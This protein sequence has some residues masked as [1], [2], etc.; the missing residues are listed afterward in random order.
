MRAISKSLSWCLIAV[1]GT[2]QILGPAAQAENWFR[3][4]TTSVEQLA[5]SIDRLEKHLDQYGTVVAKDPDVWGQARLTKYRRD[6]EKILF[7]KLTKFTPTINASITRSDQAFV[8]NA[9]ALQ[10][11]ISGPRA[12]I[13]GPPITRTSTSTTPVQQTVSIPPSNQSFGDLQLTLPAVTLQAPA[14]DA[15]GNPVFSSTTSSSTTQDQQALSPPPASTTASGLLMDFKFSDT[16][17][18]LAAEQLKFDQEKIALEPTIML[19]QLS[20]YL[21]HLNELRRISDG[22]DKADA[23]GYALHLVRLPISVMPGKKTQEGY[24]AE[25]NVIAK[26]HLHEK[27]LPE[28]FR[29]LVINDLVDQWSFPVA[30]FLD[31]PRS[32]AILTQAKDIRDGI[33]TERAKKIVT[34]AK[35]LIEA[36]EYV[37][38]NVNNWR[39]AE[40]ARSIFDRIATGLSSAHEALKLLADTNS[41]GAVLSTRIGALASNLAMAGRV[42]AKGH[43]EQNAAFRQYSELNQRYDLN[44]YNFDEA[45][46][47][48]LEAF[49]PRQSR[50][51][52]QV[53]GAYEVLSKSF[54][55]WAPPI[56][57]TPAPPPQKVSDLL[58]GIAE[59]VKDV[60]NSASSYAGCDAEC[61][62]ATGAL[63]ALELSEVELDFSKLFGDD[64]LVSPDVSLSPS[65][66]SSMPFPASQL[67]EIYGDLQFCDV[68]LVIK[69]LNKTRGASVLLLDAQKVLSEEIHAA[70]E[71]LNAH[72][73]LWVNCTQEL[74]AAVRRKDFN[75]IEY[76]RTQFEQ[77]VGE[78]QV[79]A[80]AMNSI[81]IKQIHTRALAWGIIVES[82][83]LNERLVQDMA[84]LA[85]AKNAYNLQTAWMPYYEPNPPM[86]AVQAFNDYV[87]CRW[88]IHVVAID[89]ITQ[90]QNV[91]DS[92]SQRREIQLALSLAFTSGR[93][94]AQNFTR[95]ARQLELDMETIA[96]NRTAVGFSHGDDTFG[97]RF[98]PRVQSPPTKGNI[99]TFA[100]TL[101]MGGPTRN[102]ILNKTRLEPGIRECTAVVIMPSFVPYVIF[103][104]RT[105]W[106]RLT[107]PSRKELDLRDGVGLSKEITDLRRLTHECARDQHLYRQDEVYRLTRAVEQLDARLPLQTTYAQMP[108][109]NSL[110]GFEFFNT[111][112]PDLA[113]EL[114]GF[115]GEPGL[116]AER[117][118]TFFLVGDHFSVHETRVIVGGQKV[119]EANMEL[120]SRQ[121]MQVTVNSNLN[122]TEGVVDVHVATPYGVSNHIDIPLLKKASESA[123]EDAISKHVAKKHVDKFDWVANE[124]KG[125]LKV[126]SLNRKVEDACVY[127]ELAIKDSSGS[128]PLFGT[129]IAEFR[130]L[131]FP[132]S[133]GK[134][135]EASP[136]G[137]MIIPHLVF[138]RGTKTF[139]SPPSTT[140]CTGD[141]ETALQEALKNYH[142]PAD[143]ESLHIRGYMRFKDAG[144]DGKPHGMDAMPVIKLE[145]ELKIGI[146]FCAE[147]CGDTTG[148]VLF[149]PYPPVGSP[150]VIPA[151]EPPPADEPTSLFPAEPLPTLATP[152]ISQ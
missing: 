149:D 113:P 54:P 131:I 135:V 140:E 57:T 64:S 86:E 137:M 73:H 95:M 13:F 144:A 98:Y 100:E 20:R 27:L 34:N 79:G 143:L 19:D 96:L 37:K 51:E 130:A 71:F 24:G 147:R 92:F 112:T 74:A 78:P 41:N 141:F 132:K 3:Q 89:P 99:A 5:V 14:R 65:R 97:W 67:I 142:A 15:Q 39:D 46:K 17:S 32:E 116:S 90:D 22:D 76:L 117:D 63:N 75:Q 48:S 133:K 136:A 93:I 26:P 25:V 52:S 72:S 9:L 107:D 70:Y 123:I 40:T 35:A 134:D 146:E 85:A 127:G 101:V 91:A 12:S 45:T 50:L 29:G 152:L 43:I 1:V 58:Q 2:Q 109:E 62:E 129:P 88:P 4:P 80:P 16:A 150:A 38:S 47:Q 121:V 81:S 145:S 111:G 125:C 108:F 82:A 61:I 66:R 59:R 49:S 104:M 44:A 126:S 139:V 151:P 128:Q 103:D 77:A 114:K 124:A 84:H 83:L 6:Y 28:T 30:K 102:H 11:A 8:A 148:R 118:T 23:P 120:L 36:L 119:P 7:E 10:A 138:D 87:A 33:A 115:Y 18:K 55:R 69:N 53:A 110:G 31:D 94:G 68:A 56:D 21:N 106:F 42:L 105:N 122:A 60:P